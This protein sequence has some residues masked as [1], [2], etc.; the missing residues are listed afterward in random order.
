MLTPVIIDT[1]FTVFIFPPFALIVNDYATRESIPNICFYIKNNPYA[2]EN[3]GKYS[4]S[5]SILSNLVPLQ[6]RR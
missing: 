1:S 3:V 6:N 2:C 5:F 4:F